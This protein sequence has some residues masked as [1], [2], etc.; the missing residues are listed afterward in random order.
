MKIVFFLGYSIFSMTL[1]YSILY[2]AIVY[3]HIPAASNDS[4]DYDIGSNSKAV[5]Q[6][7]I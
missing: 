6:K 1:L 2:S 4:N 5:T 3:V 7:R